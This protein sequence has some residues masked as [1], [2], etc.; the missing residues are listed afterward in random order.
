MTYKGYQIMATET[1][2]LGWALDAKGDRVLTGTPK[3]LETMTLN[4]IP[5]FMYS[6]IDAD[7]W[8]VASFETI[9]EAKEHIREE[10]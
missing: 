8:V 6:V 10:L 5:E 9:E 3:T 4:G 1:A 7:N 2:V